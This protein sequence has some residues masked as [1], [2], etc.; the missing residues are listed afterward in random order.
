[1]E[2][3]PGY[4]TNGHYQF[5]LEVALTTTTKSQF[6]AILLYCVLLG[7]LNYFTSYVAEHF[8]RRLLLASSSSSLA[9]TLHLSFR[10]HLPPLPLYLVV[11]D[12]SIFRYGA[13]VSSESRCNATF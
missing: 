10:F 7:D 12:V 8:R 5:V 6:L 11:A 3:E 13:S 2:K 9:G 1:M 4:L